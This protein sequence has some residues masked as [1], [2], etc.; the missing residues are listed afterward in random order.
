VGEREVCWGMVVMG[1]GDGGVHGLAS[2]GCLVVVV[3]L[4]LPWTLVFE[5]RWVR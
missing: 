2:R 3:G 5:C 1:G 4:I